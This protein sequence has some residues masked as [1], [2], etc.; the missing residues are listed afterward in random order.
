VVVRQ[1]LH[2]LGLVVCN[3]SIVGLEKLSGCCQ[4]FKSACFNISDDFN[5]TTSHS[6]SNIKQLTIETRLLGH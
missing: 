4:L 5:V 2:L 3:D 1:F 6:L